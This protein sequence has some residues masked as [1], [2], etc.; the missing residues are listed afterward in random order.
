VIVFRQDLNAATLQ[1]LLD[2]AT[3]EIGAQSLE[4]ILGRHS[5]SRAELADPSVWVSIEFVD[6]LLR[7]IIEQRGDR[8][9]I[10]R[11]A[12]RSISRRYLGP[13]YPL[14]VGFGSPLFVYTSFPGGSARMD[15]LGTWVCEEPR[16]GHVRLCWTP[17][18]GKKYADFLCVFRT[19]QLGRVP[20]LFALPAAHV[21]HS[22]C[23]G[24]GDPTC[25]FSLTWKQASS[26][27]SQRAGLA[28]GAA[29]GAA[30]AFELVT[31]SWGIA[32]V[33]AGF[34]IGGWAL[35]KAFSQRAEAVLRLEDIDEHRAAL[36]HVIK[37]NEERYAEL[38]EAKAQVDDKV[39]QRTRELRLATQQ[40]SATLVQLQEVDRAKTGF[41][42][43]VSHDLRTPLT[44][45][46]GPLAEM[47]AG[48]EP[49]GGYAQAVEVMQR[50]GLRLL[51]L[52][53]QLLDLAK[54][55]AGK[56]EIAR[57]PHDMRE[58]IGVVEGRFVAAASQR[59]LTLENAA[60]ATTML[61]ID[62]TWIE[63]AL[64]NLVANA[65][66]FA[67]TKVKL[68]TREL[69]GNLV[70]EVQDDGPGISKADQSKVFERFAQGSDEQARK[71]GTGL[72][73]A[74]VLEAAR[75]HGGEATVTSEL[76]VETTFALVLPRTTPAALGP[77]TARPTLSADPGRAAELF[78]RTTVESL[79]AP[80]RLQWPGPESNA[81]TVVVVEDD[82]DL[83]V[84]VSEV[85]ATRYRVLAARNGEEG[86]ALI[87]DARPDAVVSDVMMPIMSGFELCR[88]VRAVE[89]TQ[90]TPFILLT[91][92]REIG[93]VLEG[94][95]AGADDYV[96]KP[97]QPREL[98]AR[99]D[100]HV[101]L[102]RSVMEMIHQARLASLGVLAASLAHQVRNP[103]I[104]ILSG[105]PTMRSKLARAIGP[106]DDE[107]FRAMIE[108]GERIRTLV[109]DL[110]DLSRVD[111]ESVS[112]MRPADGVRACMR[113]IAASVPS[114]VQ[115]DVDLDDTLELEGKAGDL[116][117][118]FLNLIDN[119]VRAA[120]PNGR[121]FLRVARRGECVVFEAE[122]SGP[123][124]PTEMHESIF[125][126]FY[127]TRHAG[128][129]TGL[130][131]AIV[132]QVTLQHRGSIQVGR[133]QL[134]GARL[135]VSLPIGNALAAADRAAPAPTMH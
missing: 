113:L 9:F 78:E 10:E 51:E 27:R 72:G 96:A 76:G 32:V 108:S 104:A 110:M 93:R 63:A 58:L 12:V 98:L 90:K 81:P 89:S 49:P 48:R 23:V 79:R 87:T 69:D 91:A 34:A 39:E 102:R 128:E 75:L 106:R 7:G 118:V 22:Q 70:I 45:I 42:A 80:A 120:A 103:L 124:I 92:R 14:L 105:L 46:L 77:K 36:E 134:G 5:V 13:L 116:S 43:N 88:R 55:D 94:F 135:T 107:Q 2:Q 19:A 117:H 6:A 37:K 44:L 28:A 97:F 53:N 85:L 95:E 115:I 38:L 109:D 62:S 126:P 17:F 21:E 4:Q 123:G 25:V 129:G 64:T 66:R 73:L 56:L 114:S 3:D 31:Q 15:K 60:T 122:D 100:V 33:T 41:F 119:A 47:N 125:T 68:S 16:L 84:F 29:L 67:R 121:V 1:A 127:T 133:S 30:A 24:R 130:G 8:A 74:I 65:L 18:A 11:A 20:T 26:K 35:G 86:L 101:R 83:R 57:A 111:Q 132:R 82:D 40:L 71:G 131:L 52:I 54:I 59:G 50:N 99:V 61:A 112:R